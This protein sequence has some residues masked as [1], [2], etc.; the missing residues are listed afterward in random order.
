M[1]HLAALL[2]NTTPLISRFFGEMS[3]KRQRYAVVNLEDNKN[4]KICGSKNFFFKYTKDSLVFI[5]RI[6]RL[7][8]LQFE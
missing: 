5:V 4:V 7:E 3:K 1:G 6:V 2:P 8:K